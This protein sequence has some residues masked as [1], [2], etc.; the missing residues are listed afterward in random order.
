M[1]NLESWW[2]ALYYKFQRTYF[3]W[4]SSLQLSS[5]ILKC[6]D[7]AFLSSPWSQKSCL[8]L[9]LS[10]WHHTL[11]NAKGRGNT[12][13]KVSFNAFPFD[14]CPLATYNTPPTWNS[15]VDITS[16]TDSKNIHVKFMA[17]QYLAPFQSL[18]QATPWPAHILTCSLSLGY[19]LLLLTSMPLFKLF[20]LNRKHSS[21]FSWSKNH[22][23]PKQ[24][25]RAHPLCSQSPLDSH[26]HEQI[27]NI[28]PQNRP[29]W[30]LQT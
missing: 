21:L 28:Q 23:S 9:C 4:L 18:T 10:H 1:K 25:L 29:L 3:W 2:M 14:S 15:C 27:E 24:E 20:L 19:T 22:Q 6:A 11:C 17:F 8:M 7:L 16:R 5:R 26:Y 13:P 30:H 12:C